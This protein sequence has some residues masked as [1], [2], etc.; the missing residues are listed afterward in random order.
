MGKK[1][2]DFSK[3]SRTFLFNYDW[4]G[5]VRELK[6]VIVRAILLSPY[7][8]NV[9]T[10]DLL[11]MDLKKSTAGRTLLDNEAWSPAGPHSLKSLTEAFERK[12]ILQALSTHNYNITKSAESLGM[13]RQSLQYKMRTLGIKNSR[14][15]FE[16]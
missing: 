2:Y 1:L 6:H 3:D 5:N 8:S 14:Y 9:I 10:S 11:P 15:H 4:P 16:D 7:N 13:V 12:V